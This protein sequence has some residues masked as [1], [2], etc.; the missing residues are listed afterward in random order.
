ME[1]MVIDHRN[2]LDGHPMILGRPW[3]ATVDAYIVCQIGNMTIAKGPTIKYIVLYFP[4][5]PNLSVGN[6]V[7]FP[8][9]Y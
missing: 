6:Y 9:K 8:P 4:A 2:M 1:S 3:L 7:S 5:R